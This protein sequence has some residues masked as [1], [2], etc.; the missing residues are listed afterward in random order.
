MD[1]ATTQQ[2]SGLTEPRTGA[3]PGTRPT[4]ESAVSAV[5]WPAILAGAFV[6][7]AAS[8][9]LIELGSGLGLASVSAWPNS[10]ASVT[11]FSVAMA[12]WLVVV[13]WLASGTGGYVAGRMRTKWANTHT[14]EVFF[15]DT[16][17]GFITW[18]IATVV[19]AAVLTSAGTAAVSGAAHVAANAVSGATQGA[20]SSGVVAP[21]TVDTLFRASGAAN[22]TESRGPDAR[23]EAT[24]ILANGVS[25]GE[26]PAADRTYLAELVASRTGVSTAE[27]QQRVDNAIAQ[28]KA[29]EV[30]ARAAADAA[31]KTASQAAI[32]GALSMIIGAFIACVAAA[33]GGRQR[34]LHV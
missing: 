13:Q 22:T 25:S 28:A 18:A 6:A 31:R 19:V 16:A 33:L 30:K 23:A 5:S 14:H 10:G 21:Y 7:A 17:H 2:H 24:R 26:V 9:V 4:S 27:A 12:I 32:F 11:T 1:I 15:R 34:D 29:A 8:L 3:V 20:V